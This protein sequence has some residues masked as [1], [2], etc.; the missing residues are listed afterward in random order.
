M[1]LPRWFSGKEPA[2]QC[3]RHEFNPWVRKIPWRRE[4][5]PTPVFFPGKC[6]GQRSLVGY[7]PWGHKES[8]MTKRLKNYLDEMD[9]LRPLSSGFTK[10]WAAYSSLH[11]AIQTL[12]LSLETKDPGSYS[13]IIGWVSQ[14]SS[15]AQ[16]CLTL[17]LQLLKLTGHQHFH[18]LNRNNTF[19]MRI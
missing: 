11:S 16:P 10:P 12:D 9:R 3:K 2:C 6:H 13:N 18:L 1:G 4:W 15:V 17:S 5:L 8:D 14:F 7:S 19:S